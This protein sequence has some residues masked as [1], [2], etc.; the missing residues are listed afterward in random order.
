[1]GLQDALREVKD[2][3][4]EEDDVAFAELQKVAGHKLETLDSIFD[5]LLKQANALSQTASNE[6]Q[7]VI[8]PVTIQVTSFALIYCLGMSLTQR[9]IPPL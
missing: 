6:V 4:R 5:T 8:G 2:A 3:I 1:M 9:R 7:L